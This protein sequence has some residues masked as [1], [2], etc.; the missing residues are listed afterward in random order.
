[1]RLLRHILILLLV[2]FATDNTFAQKFK[3]SIGL[4]FKLHED[5]QQVS[6]KQFPFVAKCDQNFLYIAAGDKF[7]MDNESFFKIA[8]T[9]FFN[10]DRNSIL[11]EKKSPIWEIDKKALKRYY[12]QTDGSYV[13][14]YSVKTK[15]SE[16]CVIA[17][18]YRTEEDLERIEEIFDSI[19]V[20]Y[21]RYF[22]GLITTFFKNGGWIL[23]LVVTGYLFF[24]GFF[25]SILQKVLNQKLCSKL[26]TLIRCVTIIAYIFAPI[27][28]VN[29]PE[30]NNL[31]ATFFTLY[32]VPILI[33]LAL[34]ESDGEE[35]SNDKEKGSSSD[36]NNDGGD[37]DTNS[38]DNSAIEIDCTPFM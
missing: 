5:Y 15:K 29:L 6:S 31:K 7:N 26:L 21:E 4:Q 27:L 19:D 38:N 23:L 28:L 10:L 35:S 32:L 34:I 8:D 22:E 24:I 13:V 37:D 20:Y 30:P 9:T 25:Y 14:T 12:Q 17:A 16:G 3:L 11:Q 1:M 2:I 33:G 36:D 18:T